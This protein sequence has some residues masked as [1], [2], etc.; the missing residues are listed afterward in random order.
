MKHNS[1]F[2]AQ[3]LNESFQFHFVNTA[4]AN[5]NAQLYELS[6]EFLVSLNS[7]ELPFSQLKL[8]IEALIILLKNLHQQKELCNGT[9]MIITQLHHYCIEA[10]ILFNAYAEHCHILYR[11]KLST[12]ENEYF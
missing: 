1:Q 2:F 9:H 10:L 11:V 3:L 4:D 6:A 7:S 12:Q 5:D 8:K